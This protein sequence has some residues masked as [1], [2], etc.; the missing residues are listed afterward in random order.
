MVSTHCGLSV[1]E[2]GPTHQAIDDMGSFLGLLNTM[3]IE[4]ADPNQTDRIIRYIASHFGNFYV[5]MGRHK[6]P[7]ITKED[8]SIFYD[9]DYVYEYGRSD[10]IRSGS[11]VTIAAT[12]AMVSEALKALDEL[13]DVSAEIVAVSSIKKFDQTILESVKKTGKV[14][15]VEDH[16]VYSGLGA[17]LSRYLAEQ[18][19]CPQTF[20]MLG[21]REYQ[22]SGKSL[23]LYDVAGISAS[24]IAEACKN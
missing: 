9:K 4:P 7:V 14:I 17:S 19:V 24:H 15:T 22:L 2:D 3:I 21:V 10:V 12:G 23:E 16:N 18:N 11:D 1:G 5:R 6:F 8:G 13:K 20:K